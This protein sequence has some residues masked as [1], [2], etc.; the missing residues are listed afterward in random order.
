[1]LLKLPMADKGVIESLIESIKRGTS[2][3]AYLFEGEKGL[4]KTRNGVVFCY[5]IIV[6]R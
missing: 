6:P 5:G 2:V 3:H 4:K 1:M